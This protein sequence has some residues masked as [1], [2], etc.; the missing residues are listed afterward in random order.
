MAARYL[1]SGTLESRTMAFT[2]L[3]VANIALILTNVSW[4]R[5]IIATLRSPNEAMWFVVGAAFVFLGLAIYVPVL[6]QLFRFHSLGALEVAVS[7]LAGLSSV[8]WFE[9]V[10]A[11]RWREH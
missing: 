6:S 7:I 9:A 11:Y 3:T 10:K 8:L 5:S 1:G 2:T 4:S